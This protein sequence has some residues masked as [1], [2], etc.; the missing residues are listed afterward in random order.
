MREINVTPDNV[1]PIIPNDTTYHGDFLFPRKKASFESLFPVKYDI[2][3]N[4]KKYE[5]IIEI[6]KIGVI[7]LLC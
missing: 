7:L 3:I 4:T 6:I 2:N 5:E 1:A